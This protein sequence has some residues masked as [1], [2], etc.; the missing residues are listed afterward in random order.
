[1][2]QI[3]LGLLSKERV[4][5]P[6]LLQLVSEAA[7]MDPA[8]QLIMDQLNKLSAGQK[9][10]KNDIEEKINTAETSISDTRASQEE[11]N[12]DIQGKIS[13]IQDKISASQSEI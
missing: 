7:R 8:L 9:A 11:T 4:L 2:R 6:I 12:N 10:T 5:S 1:V 13:A 3:P